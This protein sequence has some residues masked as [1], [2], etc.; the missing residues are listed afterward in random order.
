MIVAAAVSAPFD[1]LPIGGSNVADECQF[2]GVVALRSGSTSCTGTVVHE[3]VVVTAA[4]CLAEGAPDRIRFGE[5]YTS[6]ERRIDVVECGVDPDYAQTE[7]SADDLGYCVLADPVDIA[8]IPLLAGCEMDAVHPG[9][10]A[11]I[12]G[13]G[14]EQ[15]EGGS[16]G[17]KRYAFTTVAS[18][19]RED[20]TIRVG[21]EGASGCIGDSGGPAIVQLADGTWRALGVLS[22]SPACGTGPSTYRT[23]VD[24]IAWLEAE[25]GFDVTPCWDDDGAWEAGPA[26][27]GFDADP[28]ES[29]GDWI[30]FCDGERIEPTQT[31]EP[32]IA[33]TSS[34]SGGETTDASSSSSSEGSSST[35]EPAATSDAGC[36]CTA[37]GAPRAG[38]FAMIWVAYVGVRRTR[39]SGFRGSVAT[40]LDCAHTCSCTR[41]GRRWPWH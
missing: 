31:C 13:Y 18:E 5:S 33:D 37:H 34:S 7:A 2:P 10:V 4:H 22:Q 26:C 8:P 12:A 6:W 41:D 23:L 30:Q 3:R 20:G 32:T 15:D 21:D 24:R 38:F 1:P 35:G 11:A 19:L 29:D 36:G 39:R 17:R 25:S 27:A 14:V 16:Y 9:T 40:G 28:R